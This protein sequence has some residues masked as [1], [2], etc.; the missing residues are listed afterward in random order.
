MAFSE[1][2]SLTTRDLPIEEPWEPL[3]GPPGIRASALD[4]S[5]VVVSGEATFVG[6]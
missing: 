5:G 2:N 1:N 4:R 6:S 3:Y